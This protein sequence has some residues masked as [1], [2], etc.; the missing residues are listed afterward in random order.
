M[1]VEK[2]EQAKEKVKKKQKS[3]N[4]LKNFENETLYFIH[5]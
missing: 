1:S 2:I 4:L 3:K 5:F